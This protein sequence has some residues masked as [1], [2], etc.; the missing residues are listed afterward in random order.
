MVVCLWFPERSPSA[1][2]ERLFGDFLGLLTTS[3]TRSQVRQ[4]YYHQCIRGRIYSIASYPGR[5][6]G[7][8]ENFSAGERHFIS[9]RCLYASPFYLTIVIYSQLC[10]ISIVTYSLLHN[11]MGRGVILVCKAEVIRRGPGEFNIIL[12]SVSFNVTF[13]VWYERDF[14]QWY[15][16]PNCFHDPFIWFVSISSCF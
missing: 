11:S 7:T 12:H 3:E 2:A 9:G 16:K 4:S 5:R 10:S 6:K 14:F 15:W 1:F 13:Y 8:F